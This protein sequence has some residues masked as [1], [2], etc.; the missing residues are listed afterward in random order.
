MMSAT[1]AERLAAATERAAEA[2]E[3]LVRA[4]RARYL[5]ERERVLWIEAVNEAQATGG[6]A[7][8]ATEAFDGA[9]ASG[10]AP[11]SLDELLAAFAAT[12]P[13]PD[14]VRREEESGR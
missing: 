1:Q 7:R 6:S 13:M 9:I 8:I 3:R 14:L 5:V 2:M 4:E 11:D 12:D 10:D